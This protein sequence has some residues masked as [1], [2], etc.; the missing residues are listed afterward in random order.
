[1]FYS[2]L[3]IF[4]LTRNQNYFEKSSPVGSNVKPSILWQSQLM[5]CVVLLGVFQKR[6]VSTFLFFWVVCSTLMDQQNQLILSR[7]SGVYWVFF[8]RS[9]LIVVRWRRLHYLFH[10]R[11]TF[12]ME[13]S[14]HIQCHFIHVQASVGMCSLSLAY[15]ISVVWI[16]FEVKVF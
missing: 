4:L 1:M 8:T 14:I 7:M 5:K 3:I 15:H 13:N 2:E 10:C 12:F 11:W 9:C 6:N 16:T